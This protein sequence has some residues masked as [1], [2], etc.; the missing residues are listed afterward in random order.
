MLKCGEVS[1]YILFT[2]VSAVCTLHDSR[3]SR[4]VSWSNLEY[5]FNM[6]VC[7]EWG[8]SDQK[9]RSQLET[10]SVAVSVLTLTFISVDRW[11]AICFPLKFKST[12]GRAKTA[13]IIIWLLALAFDIPELMVL[14]TRPRK[15]L[16]IETHFFTQCL[17]SWSDRSEMTIHV[18]KAVLL[19]TLPLIFM[20]VA[21]CQIVRVLWR[22]DN[23]PGH[24]ETMNYY[25]TGACNNSLSAI[26]RNTMNTNANNTT[27][28]QLRSRRKAAKML[29]AVVIMFAVCY[30]PVHLLSII[31][32]AMNIPTSDAMVAVA[33]LSHW[34]CY[35]NSAV[36]PVIY[37]FM[38]GKFRREFKRTF[39]QCRC[40]YQTTTSSPQSGHFNNRVSTA[41]EYPMTA[42][43]AHGSTSVRSGSFLPSS[44]GSNSR[45][46]G[47][48]YLANNNETSSSRF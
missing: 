4:H 17:P 41:C 15:E 13:I 28:G 11:Y 19:Y 8:S 25:G 48:S 38:S 22:S 6:A 23:I 21:Y 45:R 12:T 18:M 14:Q 36:N 20:S 10:V 47:R 27:E 42:S 40:L 43:A 35:A 2:V 1:N 37:N 46:Q 9:I 3:F 44:A 5:A 16:R 26:R 7:Y 24:T 31:R 33:M 32:Y 30:F 29:V 39:L 34:L